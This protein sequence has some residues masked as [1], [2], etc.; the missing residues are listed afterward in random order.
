MSE[1]VFKA[2]A[3]CNMKTAD[4]QLIVDKLEEDCMASLINM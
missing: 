3:K 1:I 4:A 2:A